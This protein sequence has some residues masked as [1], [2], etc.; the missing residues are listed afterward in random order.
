M[1]SILDN[2][3]KLAPKKKTRQEHAEDAL[4]REVWEDVN[5]EKTMAFIKKHSRPLLAVAL[6]I[7]IVVTSVQIGVRTHNKNKIA[8]TANYE[9]AVVASDANAL[10][11]IAENA[12]GAIAD[13]AIFQAYQIDGDVA[14]LESLAQN[15]TTRDFRDLARI[16][17]VSI[18][19]DEMSGPDV[20]KYLSDLN[21]KKSPFYYKSRLIIAQKYLGDGD[22]E[23]ANKWLDVII[24]D[25]DAPT[26]ISATAQTLK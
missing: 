14:H 23:N 2:K 11:A 26:I 8:I 24:S 21:T 15:G 5:N 25:A 22:K 7:M 3:K 18:N 10:A 16:H 20:E 1:A 13:L 19:G 17:I 9:T 4:Y 12:N 6:V